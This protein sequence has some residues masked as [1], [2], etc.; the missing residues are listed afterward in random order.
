MH[1]MCFSERVSIVSFVVGTLVNLGC[2][3]AVLKLGQEEMATRFA[4]IAMWQFALLMQL[5][6]AVAWHSI[7]RGR[8]APAST[9]TAAY[10]LN[11]LQPMAAA[12]ILGAARLYNTGGDLTDPLLWGAMVLP[13]AHTIWA[14]VQAP[15]ALGRG[16]AP[17]QGC[18]HLALHWWTG[19]TEKMLPL[20]L[21]AF[22][23]GILLLGG[24]TTLKI[25]QLAYFFATLVVSVTLYRCGS[26]SVWC[27]MVALAGLTVLVP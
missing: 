4:L 12:V 3:F 7:E 17:F 1:A 16:I 18:D 5:P 9:E 26:G 13:V 8:T 11:L 27:W 25:T 24:T 2:A 10:W 22:T 23:V 20:Y 21:A 15:K 19:A 14:A 6:E